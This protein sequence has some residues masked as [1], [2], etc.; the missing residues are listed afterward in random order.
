MVHAVGCQ[1]KRLFGQ[2][3]CLS[4]EKHTAHIPGQTDDERF[5]VHQTSDDEHVVELETEDLTHSICSVRI[6]D[7]LGEH[8]SYQEKDFEQREQMEYLIVFVE[9]S[10]FVEY[11]SLEMFSIGEERTGS[12]ENDSSFKRQFK[13]KH[14]IKL[15]LGISCS[16]I[17]D[18]SVQEHFPHEIQ[19]CSDDAKDVGEVEDCLGD[20]GEL[21]VEVDVIF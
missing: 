10:R 14:L 4:E 7:T 20:V 15:H 18:K 8:C 3:D 13:T 9:Q 12:D 5:M 2:P 17:T 1:L 21:E 6:P 11:V 16:S 19:G